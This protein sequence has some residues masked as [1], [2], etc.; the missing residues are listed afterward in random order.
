[1]SARPDIILGHTW[2]LKQ[3]APQKKPQEDNLVS[4]FL[5]GLE[6]IEL[7][8]GTRPIAT[9]ST[10]VIGLIGTAPDADEAAFPLNQ[11]VLVTGPAK[12]ALLGAG[13][14]LFTAVDDI[15][16]VVSAAIV[17]VRVEEGETLPA[18]LSNVVGGIDSDSGHYAGVSAFLSA[19]SRL[20]V[21]PRIIIA[22]G[23]IHQRIED[24]A[25]PVGAA[26]AP[27][28]NRLRA[29]IIAD[30][31]NTTD[32]D[33]QAARSDYGTRRVYLHDPWYEFW[34]SDID[35][36]I[37]RPGSAKIAAAIVLNDQMRGWHTSPSNQ[38]VP[39]IV[40][41]SRDIDFVMGDPTS[42]ANIL[43][44]QDIAT[45]I[46]EDGYR[47]W[48]NRTCSDDPKW[49]FLAHVRT[50]D[51]INDSLLQAHRW[52]VDRNISRT[53]VE[54]VLGGVQAFINRQIAESRIAGGRV[55]ANPELNT[56]EDMMAGRVVF[57]F[58][59]SPYGVA[60]RITFRSRM[61]DGYLEEV[62]A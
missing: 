17:V 14:T 56:P 49:A 18:T 46:Q 50:A 61:T 43:N 1:M 19:K 12:A 9:A 60:E 30:G 29:V 40:G 62:F 11:P 6:L 41:I 10:S 16:T 5:H 53:Y 28:A 20:G 25:N 15:L 33:A 4:D 8:D 24:A 42:R 57:D 22:T 7:N 44:S 21:A 31:P 35:G 32:E 26:L 38:L 51:I 37:S 48:G 23:F 3:P 47:L 52:A 54:D 36:I 55:W 45:T 39:G 34:D 58:D 27:V 59:F 13:G 2:L